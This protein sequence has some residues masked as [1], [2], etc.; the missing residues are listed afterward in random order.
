ML[1]GY[2]R[3]VLISLGCGA[4]IFFLA[5]FTN[6][7]VFN[8]NFFRMLETMLFIIGTTG[9]FIYEFSKNKIL[10]IIFQT[11]VMVASGIIVPM[12]FGI[13]EFDW[14]WFIST[15]VGIA[16]LYPVTLFITNK[17]QSNNIKKINEKLSKNKE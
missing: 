3:T 7:A 10:N 14:I 2:I 4:A 9:F 5:S 11:V 6:E 16:I 8:V 1:K 15:S 17:I 12:A 13:V